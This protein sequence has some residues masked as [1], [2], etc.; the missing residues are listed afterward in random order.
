MTLLE[1][2]AYF[3]RRY[4]T[5][6]GEI[7]TVDNFCL[8]VSKAPPSD[9]V[10]YHCHHAKG[11]QEWRYEQS[12]GHVI[13]QRFLSCLEVEGSAVGMRTCEVKQ[14]QRWVFIKP[15]MA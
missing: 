13:H 1:R 10:Q 7:R 9:V 4:L 3:A 11:N 14:S 2:H 15:P 8:D 6:E 5:H 12:T